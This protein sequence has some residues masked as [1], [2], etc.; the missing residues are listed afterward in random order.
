MEMPGPRQQTLARGFGA[1]DAFAASLHSVWY[2]FLGR[3]AAAA[4]RPGD[5]LATGRADAPPAY[6]PADGRAVPRAEFPDLFAAIGTAHGA[7]DG[8]MTFNLP[9]MGALPG[10]WFV[11]AKP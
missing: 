4:P 3:L 5:M 10:S 1:A 9:N 7:G 6:L 8:T 2:A 11:R